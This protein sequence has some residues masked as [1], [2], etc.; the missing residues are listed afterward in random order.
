MQ[1]LIILVCISLCTIDAGCDILYTVVGL[2]ICLFLLLRV[3]E[4]PFDLDWQNLVHVQPRHD[5]DCDCVVRILRSPPDK[6]AMPGR[7][8]LL[9]LHWVCLFWAN[10]GSYSCSV[11]IQVHHFLAVRLS[12]TSCVFFSSLRPCQLTASCVVLG[13]DRTI[14]IYCLVVCGAGSRRDLGLQPPHGDQVGRRHL[15]IQRVSCQADGEGEI[16]QEVV[17]ATQP[18]RPAHSVFS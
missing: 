16:S 18:T 6:H 17:Y 15:D 5:R 11:N 14:Q 8:A 2:S 7:P 13:S 9:C 10:V 1:H 4:V 3:T 12:S